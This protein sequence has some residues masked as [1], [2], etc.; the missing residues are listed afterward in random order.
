MLLLRYRKK[1]FIWNF[2]T[3]KKSFSGIGAVGA[4]IKNSGIFANPTFEKAF[5]LAVAYIS[6][7]CFY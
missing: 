1:I 7:L 3:E 4:G 2:D 6:Y 5:C